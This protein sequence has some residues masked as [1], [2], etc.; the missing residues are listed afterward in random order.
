MRIAF[1]SD[2]HANLEALERVLEDVAGQ[3][4]DQ[5]VC[6]GDIVGYGASPA[7]VCRLTME[8][9]DLTLQGNHDAALLDDIHAR[10]FNE[11]ALKAVDWT[12]KAMDPEL[13]EYWAIW[14]WLGG[15]S[16]NMELPISAT[17]SVQLVHASPRDPLAE[18]LL[19]NLP[20][21]HRR[22]LENFEQAHHRVTFFGH[23]HHPGAF[24]TRT[25]F[26]RAQGEE[27]QL[28]LREDHSYLINVG[29]VGQPRDGDP[30]LCYVI[31]DGEVVRWRRLVYNH[32]AA[33]ERIY[34]AEGLPNTLGERL[35][36]GR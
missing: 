17:D 23:T 1:I 10:G 28:A 11:R 24:A 13:E 15:L 7:E 26:Y 12:R 36:V 6:L 20:Q 21:N 14:D 3:N 22:L 33:A 31:F 27:D 34:A 29:S 4:V 16:P 9:S 35:L 32:E 8:H 19:P 25:P 30:R 18:Y 5:V 2:L